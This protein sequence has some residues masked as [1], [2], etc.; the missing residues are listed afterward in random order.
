MAKEI[1]IGRLFHI[2][3]RFSLG[4]GSGVGSD[5][6]V[7]EKCICRGVFFRL[8]AIFAFFEFFCDPPPRGSV[9][10]KT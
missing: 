7:L 2:Y 9:T 4:P 10:K 8:F 5:S 3:G 1:F 6:L